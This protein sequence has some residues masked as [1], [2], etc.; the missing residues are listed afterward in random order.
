MLNAVQP[1]T[2]SASLGGES[3]PKAGSDPRSGR[4]VHESRSNRAFQNLASHLLTPL[5]GCL[6]ECYTVVN[7]PSSLD[8]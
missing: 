7:G 2:G 5:V 8:L 3:I 6:S 4:Y 1:C